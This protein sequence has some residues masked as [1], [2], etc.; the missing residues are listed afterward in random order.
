M[1]YAKLIV[2]NSTNPML[3]NRHVI[4]LA[5]EPSKYDVPEIFFLMN[6]LSL[7]HIWDYSIVLNPRNL[8]YFC[9]IAPPYS[10]DVIC[11]WPRN[12][13]WEKK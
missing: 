5:K 1:K 3:P 7:V 9:P 2:M 10:A 13:L 6:P 8:P 4:R 11:T 12:I